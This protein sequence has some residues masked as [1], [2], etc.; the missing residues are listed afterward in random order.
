MARKPNK[1]DINLAL[2]I[3]PDSDGNLLGRNDEDDTLIGDANDN[4][5]DG[6]QGVD[7]L[8]GG[9]GADVFKVHSWASSNVTYGV[10]TITDFEAADTIDLSNVTHY[11][12]ADM[13]VAVSRDLMFSDITLTPI[14]GGN[15]M[16]VEVVA[17]D[18]RWDVDMDILGAT[19]TEANFVL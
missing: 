4:T 5:L 11:S 12:D 16:H 1:H 8:T 13:M 7:T 2:V 6:L 10:D 15:H 14:V 19:P 3:T 17:G 9:A 18:A